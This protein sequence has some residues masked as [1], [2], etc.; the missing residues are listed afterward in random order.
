MNM[1]YYHWLIKKPIWPIIR[2][3]RARHEI[4]VKIKGKRKW[5]Q[6]ASREARCAVTSHEPRGKI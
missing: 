6:P 2:Q 1:V 5:S 4:Q 3:N